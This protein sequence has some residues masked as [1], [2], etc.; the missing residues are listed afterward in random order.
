VHRVFYPQP[1]FSQSIE[2]Y[3]SLRI[4]PMTLISFLSYLL[5]FLSNQAL[6]TALIAAIQKLL[7]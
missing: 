1:E 4:P 2:G 3:N 5:K 7:H 6:L